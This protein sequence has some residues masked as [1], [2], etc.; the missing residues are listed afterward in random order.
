MPE[1]RHSVYEELSQ[2]HLRKVVIFVGVKNYFFSLDFLLTLVALNKK[3]PRLTT[4]G[5][6]ADR[7]VLV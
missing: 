1:N 4:S 6:V 2:E 5:S 7:A 3:A